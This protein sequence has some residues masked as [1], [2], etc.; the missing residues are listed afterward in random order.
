[1][2]SGIQYASERTINT[3]MPQV[4]TLGIINCT[5]DSFSDGVNYID[6]ATPGAKARATTCI[7]DKAKALLDA[8]AEM[9]DVGGDSTRPGSLCT[10][11]ELE[12]NRI[13]PILSYFCHR[14]PVSVDTHKA[15]IARRALGLG[16]SMIN[17][18]TGG[19][20]AQLVETVADSPALYTY[21]FNAYGAAHA[22]NQPLIPVTLEGVINTI[23]TW[24]AERARLLAAHGISI[25]RQVFDPGLGGFVSPDPA[26]SL[27]IIDNFWNI[28]SPATRRMLG[29]SRKGFLKQPQ[30]QSPADRDNQSATIGAKV[31]AAGPIESTLYLRVHNVSAQKQSLGSL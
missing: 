23:S 5:P 27:S 18:I 12:W 15:E 21:M 19:T 2:F 24:A 10:D 29:C 25:E 16:A 20:N 11:D 31:A 9:L 1:M 7:I 13:E 3:S 8:G 26:V 6:Q 4:L 30:E 17:D 14:V 22:F 28:K